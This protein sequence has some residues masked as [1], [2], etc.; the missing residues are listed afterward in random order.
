MVLQPRDHSEWWIDQNRRRW[1]NFDLWRAEQAGELREVLVDE[2]EGVR[3]EATDDES[4]LHMIRY[5]G[6][7]LPTDVPSRALLSE[8]ERERL[9][10]R[11][12][13]GPERERL[14]ARIKWRLVMEL[15]ED[16]RRLRSDAPELYDDL[17]RTVLEADDGPEATRHR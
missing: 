5:P 2:D 11:A 9:S 6:P 16:V 12:A 17:R 4:Y 3:I 1:S 13:E 15:P 14:R 8:S 10:N 7:R